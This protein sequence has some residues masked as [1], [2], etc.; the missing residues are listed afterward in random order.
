MLLLF[1]QAVKQ[2]ELLYDVTTKKFLIKRNIHELRHP[3]SLAKEMTLYLLFKALDE[4]RVTMNTKCKVSYKASLELPCKIHLKPGE[5]IAVKDLIVSMIV[6]SA[7]DSSV[8]VAEH[9]CGDVKSFV[10]L[11]NR[12]AKKLGMNHTH[13][14]NPTGMPDR[15]QITTAYDILKISHALQRDFPKHFKHFRSKQFSYKGRVYHTRYPLLHKPGIY[16]IKTGYICMSGF[17]VATAAIRMDKRGRPHVLIAVAMGQP[18]RQARD[19][20]VLRMINQFYKI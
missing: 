16:G 18:S 12:T 2:S 9:L 4:K 6:K 15:K 8:C 13:F 10:R 7:N 20:K 14:T 17:N 3:A 5:R 19:Q 11:M 1:A